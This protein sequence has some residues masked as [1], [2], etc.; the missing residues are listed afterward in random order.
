MF[1]IKLS[2]GAKPGKGGIL[3]AK[4]VTEEIAQIRGIPQGKDAISPNRHPDIR[5]NSDLLDMIERVRR[6]TGKPVGFKTVIGGPQWLDSLF[7]EIVKRGISS[8][9]DFITLDSSDGGGGTA[10]MPLID[11]VGLSLRESLY[12]LVDRRCPWTA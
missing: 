3:P 10:P 6:V 8:A 2:Q 7:E 12:I 4:K 9:P 5:N 1:E 11:A